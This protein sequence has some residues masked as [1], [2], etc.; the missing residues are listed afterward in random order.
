MIELEESGVF[1]SCQ[2]DRGFAKGREDGELIVGDCGCG[3]GGCVEVG[4]GDEGEKRKENK[5]GK[6]GSDG[7]YGTNGK[8]WEVPNG[9]LRT[10]DKSGAFDFIG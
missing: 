9:D 5:N 4:L 7:K 3:I 6:Y 1:G 10:S 2:V 8:L